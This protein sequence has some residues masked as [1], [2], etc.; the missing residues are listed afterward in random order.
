MWIEGN[1]RRSFLD[2]HI[3]DWNEEFLSRVDPEGLVKLLKDAGMQQIVVKCRP[4]TGLAFYPTKTGR[5]HKGLQGR[6]YVGEMIQLCHS[7]GIAVMAYFSQIFDNWAYEKPPEWRMI[8]GYGKTSREETVPD[9]DFMSRKGRYG[10]VCPNNEEYRQYVKECLTEIT[11][12]YQ[13]ETIFLD[14]PFSRKYA[15]VR[16]AGKNILRGPEGKCQER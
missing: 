7:N 14:M 16:A 13:F 5:M 3:D 6:D 4:H 8:N 9:S 2:M 11:E 1:Y 10:I 15:I 12:N